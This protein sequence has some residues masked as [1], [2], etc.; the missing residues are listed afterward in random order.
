MK[1]LTLAT[2]SFLLVM[3]LCSCSGLNNTPSEDQIL[4][5]Y[6]EKSVETEYAN[7][8]TLEIKRSQ[9]NKENKAFTA[10]VVITGKD[11]YADY[12]CS[13]SLLYNYYDDQGWML[14]EITNNELTTTCHSG[15]TLEELEKDIRANYTTYIPDALRVDDFNVENCL[16][17]NMQLVTFTCET[18]N[19]HLTTKYDVVMYYLYV[20][21]NWIIN[22][23][24]KEPSNFKI[25]LE[26]TRWV[27]K[28]SDW[29]ERGDWYFTI[30]SISDDSKT[31][32]FEYEGSKYTGTLI[33][34]YR[35]V[36][37]ECGAEYML[38]RPMDR[39]TISWTAAEEKM[40]YTAI[41]VY[42]TE[43]PPYIRTHVDFES[44]LGN[45][46]RPS[47]NSWGSS[48]YQDK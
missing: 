3:V 18:V 48:V 8:S 5:D 41:E 33:S 45:K 7:F 29:D 27:E 34:D 13:T 15:R 12:T 32:V 2:L 42:P 30:K 47:W 35:E 20:N 24:E 39:G 44:E 14:D 16:D 28:A 21:G 31:I 25:N 36:E 1:K 43:K 19:N 46:A 6:L 26:G 37:F 11:E 22:N 17:Q 10:D 4:S 9:L 38:D 23:T 40:Y